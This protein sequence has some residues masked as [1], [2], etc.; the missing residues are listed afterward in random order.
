M[1]ISPIKICIFRSSVRMISKYDI[2]LYALTLSLECSQAGTDNL[3]NIER[4][5][6]K[7]GPVLPSL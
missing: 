1:S 4:A 6:S 2:P 7:G 3:V 5:L